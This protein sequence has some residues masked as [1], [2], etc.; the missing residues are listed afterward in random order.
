[1]KPMKTHDRFLPSRFKAV[2][3]LVVSLA[4][5]SGL[6]SACGTTELDESGG[7]THFLI[8]CESDDT[9]TAVSADLQCTDGYCRPILD[10][11]AIVD[12]GGGTSV[13]NTTP[14]V[15]PS[16]DPDDA[17]MTPDPNP[18]GN[19]NN[20]PGNQDPPDSNPD[21]DP[22]DADLVDPDP[23]NNTPDPVGP[24]V[25]SPGCTS[26]AECGACRICDPPTDAGPRTCIPAPEN[27]PCATDSNSCTLD[28]CEGTPLH[29][30]HR[31][32]EGCGST[33]AESQLIIADAVASSTQQSALNAIDGS[34]GTRWESISV[35]PSWI[36][37]DLGFDVDLSSI[38]IDWETASARNYNI[39]VAPDGTCT[40][41]DPGCLSTDDPWTV[42][43]TSP[44]YT[45]NPN[46]RIDNITL[47]AT[48]RYVRMKGTVR[49]T[50]YGYSLYEF[51][52]HGTSSTDCDAPDAGADAGETAC[53]SPTL[54]RSAAVASSSNG[55]N[56]P[57]NVIDTSTATRWESAHGID[58]Q[59]IYVD[60]G[61]D[62]HIGGVLLDWETASAAQF[63]I[64]VA[65]DGT[66]AGNEPGCLS[67]STPWTTV[68]SILGNSPATNHQIN[69]IGLNTTGRYVRMY[70]TSRNT[71][72]G[73]SLWNISVLSASC[74]CGHCETLVGE[75]CVLNSSG[76]TCRP[77]VAGGCDVAETC[78]GVSPDCPVDVFQSAGV[79]CRPAVAPCDVAEICNGV[80]G[81]CPANVTSCEPE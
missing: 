56:T 7:E 62:R 8:R 70:G 33:C 28:R 80:N 20:P 30:V 59:W 51:A 64:Q 54:A 63:V 60:L 75:E 55:G 61:Q 71:A 9:C 66:C 17:A 73:Y 37:F 26:D 32:I 6:V 72:Y 49:M 2:L 4:L 15:V 34:T 69:H 35:D 58:P 19:D 67:T 76:T 29:C 45:V 23:D 14:D 11:A 10:A 48:G 68:S 52:I 78:D 42:E 74:A 22:P 77:A 21:S 38:T 44:T 27:T 39:Q 50:G 79:E 16:N 25:S 47:N 1:M 40:G 13:G 36:Y 65:P 81:S 18:P 5:S 12:D 24:N 31:P 43:Y 46:H 3:F 53:L 41:N 57:A